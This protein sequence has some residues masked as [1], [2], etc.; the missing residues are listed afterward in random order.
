M[1]NSGVIGLIILFIIGYAL[2]AI[3]AVAAIIG[4]GI[5][6][7]FLISWAVK[8]VREYRLRKENK[9][10]FY[11]ELVSKYNLLKATDEKKVDELLK[12]AVYQ[13]LAMQSLST[14][15]INAFGTFKSN[16]KQAVTSAS[17]WCNDELLQGMSCS[18]SSLT[19]RK[20]SF[21][22]RGFMDISLCSYSPFQLKSK[23]CKMFF[24][25]NFVI[26][27]I[28]CTYQILDYQNIG[29]TNDECIYVT[30]QSGK[31]IRGASPVFYEY[32][33][34]RVNGGPDRRYKN[35][36]STP[37]YCH[38]IFRIN[39]GSN[40]I[41]IMAASGQTVDTLFKSLRQFKQDLKTYPIG[42]SKRIIDV[43]LSSNEYAS[44]IRSIV[45]EHGKD[46]LTYRVFI[47]LLKDYKFTKKYPNII[48][49]YELMQQQNYM[50]QLIEPDMGY[51][52]LEDVKRNISQTVNH[53]EDEM[54]TVLAFLGYGLQLNSL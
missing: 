9:R 51:S 20:L 16:F 49:I 5:G 52:F 40:E 45:D 47:N 39:S 7:S 3:G 4:L 34:Q 8:T 1:K 10:L 32:L 28:N 31:L 30:E 24:Y 38:R 37:V 22:D 25:P 17:I 48:S 12:D 41:Q 15:I 18:S 26:A 29:L 42:L 43:N 27:E 13:I 14:N 53:D 11:E 50:R 21:E 6:L 54:N 33:H 23:G 2:I 19:R 46:I 44:Q 35:N 36:P